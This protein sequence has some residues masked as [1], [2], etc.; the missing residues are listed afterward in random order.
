MLQELRRYIRHP[1]RQTDRIHVCSNTL[2]GLRSK[3]SAI[4]CF[5][6]YNPIGHNILSYPLADCFEFRACLADRFLC[7][8][9][10]NKYSN[11]LPKGTK[12]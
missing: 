10:I 8:Q 11:K 2:V 5:E 1:I 4:N 3:N 7:S 12:E 9:K 6:L